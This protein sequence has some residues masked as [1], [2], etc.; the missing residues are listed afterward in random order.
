MNDPKAIELLE[1]AKGTGRACT[2]KLSGYIEKAEKDELKMSD[3][4]PGDAVWMLACIKGVPY[5][6]ELKGIIRGTQAARW[7]RE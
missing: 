6:D 3:L 7:M 1:A 5:R 4:L 2:I